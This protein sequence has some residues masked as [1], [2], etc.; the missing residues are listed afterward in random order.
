MK[1]K[2]KT[3]V[4][5]FIV[6]FLLVTTIYISFL[7]RS[8]SES[9]PT[10]IK[11]TKAAARTYTKLIALNM[12][13]AT[14]TPL[15]TSAK[16]IEDGQSSVSPTLPT[17]SPTSNLLA[18]NELTPTEPL[19]PILSE[20]ITPTEVLLAKVTI[21]STVSAAVSPT[22]TKVKTLPDSGWIKPL[23]LMFVFAFSLILFSLL[24]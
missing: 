14:P 13:T 20:T 6:G 15:P 5:L 3:A 23:H 7:L 10:T 9:A 19:T 22:T 17:V 2:I 4:L 16:Y 11:K 18:K 1:N 12:P 24:Y 21:T 8:E